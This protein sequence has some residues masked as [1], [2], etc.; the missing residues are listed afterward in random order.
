MQYPFRVDIPDVGCLAGPVTLIWSMQYHSPFP[1]SPCNCL[2][3]RCAGRTSIPF[4]H[5]YALRVPPELLANGRRRLVPLGPSKTLTS[6]FFSSCSYIPTWHGRH[7]YLPL[8]LTSPSSL[9]FYAVLLSFVPVRYRNVVTT[10]TT[11]TTITIAT[12]A[13]FRDFHSSFTMGSLHG[14]PLV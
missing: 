11:I 5:P 7:S 13:L 12:V 1:S 9:P 2:A 10:I 8:R 3:G 4:L 6:T 14:L